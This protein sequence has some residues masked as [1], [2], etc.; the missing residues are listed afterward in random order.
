MRF[1]YHGIDLEGFDAEHNDTI[2]N[3]RAVEL[4]VAHHWFESLNG[5]RGLEV[6]NVLSHYGIGQ[7][8]RIV[9]LHEKAEGVENISVFDIGPRQ[10]YEWIVSIS[11]LEHVGPSPGS[12]SDAIEHL[13]SLLLPGGS[14]LVSI[15]GGYHSALD[16]H[17]ATNAGSSRC[18]T[19]VRSKT[20]WRQTK[21]L[22]FKPYGATTDWAESVFIGE[23]DAPAH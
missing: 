18:C 9:D 10:S 8:R 2:K 13:R 6:G 21:E 4:A 17:L 7:P 1:K 20:G 16:E 15:P 12:A 22:T 19:L 5:G 23:F 3:E 14:M 11:T